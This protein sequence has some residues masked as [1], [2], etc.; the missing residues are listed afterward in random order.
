MEQFILSAFADEIDPMLEVQMEVLERHGVRHIEMRG[1]DGKNVSSLTLEEARVIRQRLDARGFRVSAV[2]SPIGKIGITEPFEPHLEQFRHTLDVAEILG[3][4]F[5]RMFS[6]FIPQGQDPSLFRDEVMRRWR[7][8]LAAAEGRHVILLHENEK[9]IYG[10]TSARCLDLLEEMHCPYL[11]ATFDPA[12]FVQVGQIP[13]PEA[14]SLLRDHVVYMHIKDAMFQTG[15][16][17]PAGEG[18]SR[19]EDVLRSLKDAG[20]SGFLSLEPHLANSL[21]GGGPDLFAV[22]FDALD[23]ILERIGTAGGKA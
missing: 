13:Y 8:F 23:R 10:D 6:F 14:F 1:V 17:V 15:K 19:V 3:A 16:V 12:N 21:P 22:A 2:G 7:A 9:D 18:E 11:K 4:P 20:W 5:I